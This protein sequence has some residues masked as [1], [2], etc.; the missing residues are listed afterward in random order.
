[1][2]GI[3]I[4]NEFNL[5]DKAIG[6][7]FRRRD[8]LSDEVIWSVFSK[9]AQSNSRFNALDRL[10]VVIHSVRMPVGFGKKQADRYM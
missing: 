8:Q 2:V 7:S 6:I 4:R 3:T 1:M 10:I 9:V 5:H